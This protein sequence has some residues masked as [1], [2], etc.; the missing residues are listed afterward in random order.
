MAGREK[1]SNELARPC[2]EN[3]LCDFL[4]KVLGLCRELAIHKAFMPV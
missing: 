1:T 4:W 3:S 2:T